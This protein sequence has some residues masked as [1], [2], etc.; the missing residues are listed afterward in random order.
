MKT[1][2]EKENFSNIL[3]IEFLN[4]NWTYRIVCNQ[5]APFYDCNRVRIVNVCP[6]NSDPSGNTI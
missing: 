2:L 6:I 4:K 3:K 1:T 5:K